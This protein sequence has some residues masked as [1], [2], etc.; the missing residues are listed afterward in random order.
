MFK[1]RAEYYY[2][3][4]LCVRSKAS[5]LYTSALFVWSDTPVRSAP[6]TS[7]LSRTRGDTPFSARLINALAVAT[8]VA[9]A[10]IPLLP[11]KQRQKPQWRQGSLQRF[12]RA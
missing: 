9:N 6:T 10:L 8:E 5:E 12:L 11:A 1:D 7:I 2:L 3:Y 4:L